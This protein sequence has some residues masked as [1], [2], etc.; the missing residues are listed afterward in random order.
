MNNYTIYIHRNKINNKAYIGQTSQSVAD[1]WGRGSTYKPCPH[2]YRAIQ[3]YGWDSFEHIV[4]ATGLTLE[5]ANQME[6]HL[7]ALFDTTN[8]AWGYN[9]KKGGNNHSHSEETKRKLSEAAKNRNDEWREKQRQSHLGIKYSEEICEKRRKA[10]YCVELD[11]VFKSQSEAAK[12]L[13]LTQGNISNCLAG[14]QKQTG[15]YHFEWVLGEKT[16]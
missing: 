13:G 8:P 1:R 14:R 11:K 3:K 12:E 6:E 2:F 5:Q 16:S 15:G 4:W 9:V 10:V 7:I